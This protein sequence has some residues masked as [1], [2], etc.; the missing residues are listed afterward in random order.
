MFFF[1]RISRGIQLEQG[2]D[3]GNLAGVSPA[4]IGPSLW[5]FLKRVSR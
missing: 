4:P 2:V 3:V 5:G 1:A